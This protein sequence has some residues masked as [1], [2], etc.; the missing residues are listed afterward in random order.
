M[1]SHESVAYTKRASGRARDQLVASG[2]LQRRERAASVRSN[3]P[4]CANGYV[5]AQLLVCGER[6][7]SDQTSVSTGNLWAP[8]FVIPLVVPGT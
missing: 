4:R 5:Q 7:A 2:G 8:P 3:S 1:R 6:L